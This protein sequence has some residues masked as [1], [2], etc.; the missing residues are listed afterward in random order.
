MLALRLLRLSAYGTF[1]NSIFSKIAGHG[2]WASAL[3]DLYKRGGLQEYVRTV[4]QPDIC[5]ED[6][7]LFLFFSTD[8]TFWSEYH[9]FLINISETYVIH[10]WCNAQFASAMWWLWRITINCCGK[11]GSSNYI[12]I[13]S[14]MNL[15]KLVMHAPKAYKPE[16]KALDL[17]NFGLS[18]YLFSMRQFWVISELALAEK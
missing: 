16:T 1:W 5:Q 18:I 9:H 6:C 7:N 14:T 4:T 15:S 13:R 2:A 17:I 3:L 8:W 11:F 12:Y 10:P